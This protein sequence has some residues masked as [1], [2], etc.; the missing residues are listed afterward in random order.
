MYPST[1]TAFAGWFTYDTTDTGPNGRRWYTL[2]NST[3]FSGSDTQTTMTIYRSTGGQ[4][5]TP[6]SASSVAVGTATLSFTSCHSGQLRY[7][8]ATEERGPRVGLI[9]HFAMVGSVAMWPIRVFGTGLGWRAGADLEL[10]LRTEAD[11]WLV[12]LYGWWEYSGG[13]WYAL[14]NGGP[15][16][17]RP[18]GT[19]WDSV[20]KS[21]SFGIYASSGGLFNE[22]TPNPTSSM[23]GSGTIQ[24]TGCNSATLTYNFTGG[25]SG[26]IPLTR[27]GPAP[28]PVE[29]YLHECISSPCF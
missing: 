15:G 24:F 13:E 14:D 1:G 9:H 5:D 11:W 17:G 3:P 21:A 7:S 16:V 12:Y 23:V 28:V 25:G 10:F 6:P 19:A 4:F 29:R 27:L 26:S 20:T 2:Q 22:A 18:P 8:F